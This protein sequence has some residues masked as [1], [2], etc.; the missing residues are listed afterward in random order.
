MIINDHNDGFIIK[1]VL[2][3]P[4]DTYMVG[5]SEVNKG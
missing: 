1:N 2:Q 4:Y 5:L 3:S